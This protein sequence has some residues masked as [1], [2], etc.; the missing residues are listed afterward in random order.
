MA[1]AK[2]TNSILFVVII[3]PQIRSGQE[4][5]GQ[6]DR[7]GIPDETLGLGE[8]FATTAL[9]PVTETFADPNSYGF[10]KG[11]STAYTIDLHR[12]LQQEPTSFTTSPSPVQPHEEV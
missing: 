10:R 9:E 2:R 8:S 6:S 12:A 7:Q 3:A 1:S 11:R 4:N 5:T